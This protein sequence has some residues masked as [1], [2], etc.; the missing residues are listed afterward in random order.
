MGK[1]ASPSKRRASPDEY[2]MYVDRAKLKTAL[3]NVMRYAILLSD[4]AAG[5]IDLFHPTM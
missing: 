2:Y 4:A 1:K 3:A 5:T